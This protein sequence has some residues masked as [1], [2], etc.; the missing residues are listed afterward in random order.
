MD[1]KVEL[2]QYMKN[3]GFWIWK[4]EVRI[5]ILNSI[6]DPDLVL[7]YPLIR[8]GKNSSATIWDEHPGSYFLCFLG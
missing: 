6:A 1:L 4:S 5:R 7:F 3:K 8:D 2:L